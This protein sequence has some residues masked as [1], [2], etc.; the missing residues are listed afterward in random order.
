[1]KREIKVEWFQTKI[2]YIILVTNS[3]LKDMI[4]VI[5][6]NVCNFCLT[7]RGTSFHYMYKC[8]HTHSFWVTFDNLFICFYRERQF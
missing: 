5:A 1:M 2:C 3:I 8:E 4:G 6:N 7:E